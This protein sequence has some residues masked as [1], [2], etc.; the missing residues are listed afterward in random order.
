M[1]SKNGQLFIFLNGGKLCHFRATQ[2]FEKSGGFTGKGQGDGRKRDCPTLDKLDMFGQRGVWGFPLTH[3]PV[4]SESKG[5]TED[6]VFFEL[7]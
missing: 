3:D 4:P 2:T 6:P 5:G 7:N 1:K